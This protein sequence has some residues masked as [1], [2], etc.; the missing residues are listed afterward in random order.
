[1]ASHR[2]PRAVV[3]A[4]A[5]ALVMQ[6]VLIGCSAAADPVR[7]LSFTWSKPLPAAACH[8]QEPEPGGQGKPLRIAGIVER[9]DL[10]GYACT[11][12]IDRRR[13]DAIYRF[14]SV[15]NV[16]AVPRERYACWVMYS[17][18]RVTFLYA[19]TDDYYGAPACEFACSPK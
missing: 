1:M 9:S 7:H 6:A 11:V 3:R 18:A 8:L 13:F 5:L 17:P 10:L 19:Y 4:G 16:D 14:C 2:L 12:H 15:E